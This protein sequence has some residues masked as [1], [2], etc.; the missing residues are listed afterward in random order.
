MMEAPQD[1]A[2]MLRLNASG[3]GIKSI[4]REKAD[5]VLARPRDA[6]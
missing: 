1:V 4:A 3:M 6:T 5:P 2:E